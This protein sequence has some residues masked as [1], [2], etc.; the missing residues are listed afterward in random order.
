M[1]DKAHMDP[2]SEQIANSIKE[3]LKDVP[4]AE[5][6]INPTIPAIP[7]HIAGNIIQLLQRVQVTG[8]EAIAWTE[9]YQ[10][11]QQFVQQAQPQGV[12]FM[13]LPAKKA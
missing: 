2:Q 1:S 4:H 12:P 8:L 7:P 3:A 5:V 6:R 11:V 9:A 10:Y 13:G